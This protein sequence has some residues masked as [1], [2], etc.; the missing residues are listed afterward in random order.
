VER[1][2]VHVGDRRTHPA[3]RFPG[4]NGDAAGRLPA[5]VGV[6]AGSS[7][8]RP[9][10]PALRLAGV[11]MSLRDTTQAPSAEDVSPIVSPVTVARGSV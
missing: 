8:P 11:I 9:A 10:R 4:L 6:S 7:P 1:P 5:L 2:R 3:A